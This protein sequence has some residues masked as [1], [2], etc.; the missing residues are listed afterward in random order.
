MASDTPDRH[1]LEDGSERKQ[2]EDFVRRY[3]EPTPRG[4]LDTGDFRPA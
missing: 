3:D 1:F 2:G 4:G